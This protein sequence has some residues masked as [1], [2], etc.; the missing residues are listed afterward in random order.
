[1][2]E[3]IIFY[4][5]YV[6]FPLSIWPE[7]KNIW[8]SVFVQALI[9]KEEV[10]RNSE[11]TLQVRMSKSHSKILYQQVFS[12]VQAPLPH[13]SWQKDIAEEEVREWLPR[14]SSGQ[15]EKLQTG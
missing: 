8:P 1:M 12:F 2:N 14:Q 5:L 3:N 7:N 15:T 10:D 13:T 6:L 11:H 9:E 4:I